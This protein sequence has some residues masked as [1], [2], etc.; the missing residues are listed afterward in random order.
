MPESIRITSMRSFIIG[1]F[2]VILL[3]PNLKAQQ[4][5]QFSMYMFNR[6]VL[7][8]AYGGALEATNITGLGRAQW[9]GIDGSP[10]TA[11]LSINGYSQKLHGGLGAYV[12]NDKLGSWGTLGLKASYSYIAN[13]SE[14]AKLNI[15]VGGGIYQKT[16]DGTNFV[17][18]QDNGIDPTLPTGINNQLVP[19]LDAGLYFHL[20]RK[21][22]TS[23]AY[24]Q[25]AFYL[26]ASV[27]HILE[28]KLSDLVETTSNQTDLSRSINAMVGG[29]IDLSPTVVLSPSANF[30]LTGPTYQVDVNANIY[31][32]PMVFGLSHR[33][34][35][36][37]TG[38]VG[39]N[40]STY[41]FM[42]YSYDYTLSQLGSFT[43]GSHE[44][45]VSYTFPSKYKNLAPKRGTRTLNINDV[46]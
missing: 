4:D 25:D 22:N 44:I 38:I 19:D 37:F 11:T 36:S 12:V 43:T 6:Y 2:L 39:F 24:P 13:F 34:G 8:P 40:A 23:S 31:V 14:R 20:L 41:L 26:G 21:N 45:I 17:Y 10:S 30:R 35:D 3:A 29:S 32:S 5:Y 7:N 42:A 15:G 16:L 18:N 9:V 1:I 33:L 27:G 28:P 46:F